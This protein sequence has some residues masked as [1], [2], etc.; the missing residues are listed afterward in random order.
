MEFSFDYTFSF[1]TTLVLNFQ[2]KYDDHS[3]LE[4][5]KLFSEKYS[6]KKKKKEE[7]P[8][9]SLGFLVKTRVDVD[10]VLGANLQNFIS[11]D[12]SY[13]EEGGRRI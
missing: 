11:T 7:S 6:L 10:S 3:N 5:D 2:V 8:K 13:E 9:V 4:T 1:F 12:R